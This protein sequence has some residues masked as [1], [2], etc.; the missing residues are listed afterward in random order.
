MRWI[1][2][3][4]GYSLSVLECFLDFCLSLF[5]LLFFFGFGYSLLGSAINDLIRSFSFP[6][7]WKPCSFPPIHSLTGPAGQLFPSWPERQ[8]FAPCGCNLQWNWVS[9]VGAVSLH[10][11]RQHDWIIG[12]AHPW[13]ASLGFVATVWKKPSAWPCSG[14]ARQR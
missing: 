8:W 5:F 14:V 13:D 6:L 12:L 2:H 7:L 10:R 11:W 9:P 4:G 1:I 3:I